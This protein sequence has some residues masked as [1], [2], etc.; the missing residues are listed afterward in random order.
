MK[1]LLL[2]EWTKLKWPVLGTL[3]TL[4]LAVSILTGT[5]YR[6]YSLEKDLEAWEIG[7]S[8]IVFIFPIIAV[9]PVCWLMYYE[10]KDKFLW[11]TLTRVSKGQYILAKWIVVASSSFVIMF[12]AMSFGVITAL[13]IKPDIIPKLYLL[14]SITGQPM[15]RSEKYHFMG[16]FFVHHPLRYGLLLSFWQGI[17]SAILATLGF[18]FSLYIRNIF[19]I[20]TGPF[21]YVIVENFILN[22]LNL[23][24]YRIYIS[25]N[26]DS[27][28]VKRFGTFPLLCGP[29]LALLF[30]TFVYIYYRKIKKVTV[31][32]S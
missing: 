6:D 16:S 3:I 18:V 13:Y 1:N 8:F 29:L 20:L 32:P 4:T 30:I 26:P 14:D 11:Y 15:P 7:I 31:Y 19:V 9:I 25:F 24:P 28:N 2:L 10:R 12:V 23:K 17:L 27:Y 21:I 22:T 5:L